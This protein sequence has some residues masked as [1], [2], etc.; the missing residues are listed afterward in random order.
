M[1][2]LTHQ[3]QYSCRVRAPCGCSIKQAILAKIMGGKAVRTRSWGWL[4]SL[5]RYSDHE[6]F[7]GG[8]ILS[9][10]WVLTA[11]HCVSDMNAS[12]IIINA[13]SNKL[14]QSTQKRRV[15][16]IVSHPYY[17]PDTYVN[18]IALI[19]LSSS[20]D[21]TDPDVAKICLPLQTGEVIHINM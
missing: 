9:S 8:S 1:S 5:T 10:S 21:M 4:V 11:A 15:A 3:Q 14:N 13:G 17:N 7:C 6:H 19:Q 18:D 20:L 16:K 12:D 2:L